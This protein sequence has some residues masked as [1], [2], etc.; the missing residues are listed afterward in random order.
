MGREGEK[1]AERDE[2]SET[3]LDL[4]NHCEARYERT[5]CGHYLSK[6]SAP[7]REAV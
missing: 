1:R 3:G 2:Q 4:L 5:G 6:P 7:E